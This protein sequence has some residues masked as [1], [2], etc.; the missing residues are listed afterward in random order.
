MT[1]LIRGSDVLVENY[2]P[3]K[4]DE[5]GLGYKTLS[6]INPRLIYCSITGFGQDG[7][8]AHRAAYDVAISAMGGLMGITG[9]ENGPPM[10]VGVAITDV[11][12]GLFAHGAILA[13]LYSRVASGK[14]QYIDCSLLDCQVA[15]LVNIASNYLVAGK[16]AKRWGTAHASIVPYQSF[17]SSDGYFVVGALNDL[18]FRKLCVVLNRPDLAA[19][20]NYSTNPL[21]VKHRDALIASLQELFLTRTTAQWLTVL[22]DSELPYAP[23]NSISEVFSDP[24]IQSRQMVTSLQHDTLG[25]V[26]VVSPPVKMSTTPTT[27]R[28]AP[29]LLNQHMMDILGNTLGYSQAK[30]DALIAG[31]A[32]GRDHEHK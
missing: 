14:G 17:R 18:Q 4:L 28:T 13:A 24:Q 32:F 30:I 2:V 11:T 1:D 5:M 10:K 22:D 15:G 8:Y 29:P 26:K 16:E 27:A 20:P 21:R 12:T 9:D 19:N 6:D 23:V 31:G 25:Q 3:G 7:P